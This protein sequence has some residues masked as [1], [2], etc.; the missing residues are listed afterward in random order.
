MSAE[1]LLLVGLG[2]PGPA[3]RGNRHNAGFLALDTVADDYGFSPT[4]TQFRGEVR[5]GTIEGRRV[6]ALKPMTFMNNSGGSVAELARFYK[7]PTQ[8][9][10]V[11]H[12]ELDLSF[13]KVK[14]KLNG[15]SGGHNGLKSIDQQLG[16]L[17]WRVRI[18]I[19]HPG[20]ASDVT[21]YVLSDFN[22]QEKPLLPLIWRAISDYIPLLFSG[23]AP[24]F[25]T[26]MAEAVGLP[27]NDAPPIQ[28]ASSNGI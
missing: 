1:P 8:S 5:E 27:E 20:H 9:V 28:K 7:L 25:M 3:Y 16:N 6:Y 17:Y 11:L 23:D 21:P 13:A 26:R 18:G 4:K 10:I 22:T 12:D 14:A 19:G 24:L 15:G 2:N